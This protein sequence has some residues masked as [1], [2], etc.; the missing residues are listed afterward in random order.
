MHMLDD[1]PIKK[2]GQSCALCRKSSDNFRD[3]RYIKMLIA[4]INALRR[5]SDMEIKQAKKW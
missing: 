3:L 2:A 1:L 4:R 5:K